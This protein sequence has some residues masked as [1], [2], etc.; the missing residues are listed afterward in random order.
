[1]LIFVYG[2]LKRGHCRAHHME[3]QRFVGTAESQPRY[4]MLDVGTYPGLIDAV[5]GLAIT[6]EVWDVDESCLQRLDQVESVSDG[7]YAR[8]AIAL[9]A[10]FQDQTIEAYFYL[11]PIT[12]M[13]DCGSSWDKEL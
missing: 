8:R 7:E 4:R 9:A 3:G 5:G 10:P 12:G 2:T 13:P 1:M 11:R 6:G